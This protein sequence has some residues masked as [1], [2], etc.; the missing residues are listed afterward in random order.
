VKTGGRRTARFSRTLHLLFAALLLTGTAEGPS[1]SERALARDLDRV[2]GAPVTERAVWAVEVKSLDTG[3][4][5]Y[6]RNPR[7]LVMPASNMKILTLAAAAEI[8]GWDYRF[9][10][11]LEAAAPIENGALQGDLFV[12]GS[13]DPSINSRD[14]RAAA[15][16][17]EWAAALRAQGITRID[18]GIV[19]DARAFDAVPLGQ[20]WAW[21]YLDA[22]YAAPIG[23]LEYNEDVA[24]LTVHAGAR[25]GDAA[26][27]ELT[28]GA[29]LTLIHHVI[30]GEAG[31]KTAV[32]VTRRADGAAVDVEGSIAADAPPATH[33]VAVLN[34]AH[35]FA[36]SLLIALTTRGM[37][38]GGLPVDL[39]ERGAELHPEPRRVLVASPSPPLRDIATTMMK[40][41]QN[42]YA[43]TLLKALGAARGDSGSADAGRRAAAAVFTSWGIPPDGY[44]QADG[45]GL[46]RYDYLSADTI[47]AVLEH[48]YKDP[49]HKDAFLAALP[50]AGRDGTIASRMKATRAEAN[51]LAKTGSISNVRALSGYVRARDGESLAI[52]ILANNFTIPPATVNYIADVAVETL[53]NYSPR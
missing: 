24:V 15:L 37:T 35:Y 50:V 6:A 31:S 26:T 49:R 29:G 22:D 11:R 40:A 1:R 52:S 21:D 2:F 30:T 34:P 8:L 13:G 7:T 36:H 46:S 25:A 4:V 28:P 10:T 18:G 51:A 27:L 44:V 3:R 19:A 38:V 16:F 42:L 23:A 12:R 33:P 53:A 5:L 45:S 14:G 47:V 32:S 20:G 17:D 9:T 41:S 48:L 39:A 43:E